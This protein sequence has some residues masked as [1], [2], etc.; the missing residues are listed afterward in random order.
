[1]SRETD[2]RQELLERIRT[3]RAGI[4]TFVQELNVRGTR[5]T[6]VSIVG[7][8]IVT[9]LTAG[10]ALGG[11]RFTDS[12]SNVLNVSDE[13]LIWRV[14]CLLAMVLS[15]VVAVATNM[16]KSRDVAARLVK[17]EATSVALEG[18]ETLVEFEQV[19]TADAV[20]QYQQRIADI[21]F[22][23]DQVSPA[24]ATTAPRR[25]SRERPPSPQRS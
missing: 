5:L 13:S 7:S 2:A 11:T 21:P 20:Q 3:R 22:I 6:N 14:L 1:M 18:L 19:S 25:R 9:V 12:T 15:I 24:P 16:Y 8:A 10:P 17:A 4:S 23:P